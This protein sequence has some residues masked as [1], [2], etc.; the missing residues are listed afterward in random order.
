MLDTN[1]LAYI[2]KCFDDIAPD[3]EEP[4]TY[5]RY[6]STTPGDQ[7]LG[8][9]DTPNYD[10]LSITATVRDLSLEEVQA[11]AGV[12][13]L[14]D[15]EIKIRQTALANQPAYAD[16]IIYSG[17]NYKPKRINGSY[18]GGVINWTVRAGKK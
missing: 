7:I 13:V 9:T 2:R 6:L 8:T 11:S 17:A 3:T 16:R 18:L 4:I 12:Y 1:D 10:D 15:V 14:G 5:R